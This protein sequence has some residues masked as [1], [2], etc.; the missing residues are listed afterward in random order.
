MMKITISEIKL[1]QYERRLD[2][3]TKKMI[4]SYGIYIH[5][6]DLYEWTKHLDVG[7]NTSNIKFICVSLDFNT[8]TDVD[9]LFKNVDHYSLYWI[10]DMIYDMRHHGIIRPI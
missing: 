5:W 8:M 2:L 6:L 10:H 7:N 9:D 4:I 3:Y 1:S